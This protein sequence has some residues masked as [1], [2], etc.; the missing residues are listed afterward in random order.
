VANANAEQVSNESE[1]AAELTLDEYG[2]DEAE[3][4]VVLSSLDA[5]NIDQEV[6]AGKHDTYDDALAYVIQRGLAEIKRQRLAAEA[7]REKSKL[8]TTRDLYGKMLEMNPAL[9]ANPDF[10]AKMLAE[11]GVNK[12]HSK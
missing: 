10:V 8:K 2:R 3:R 4:T 12:N 11:L 1:Q 7:L 6:I 9:V 5:E